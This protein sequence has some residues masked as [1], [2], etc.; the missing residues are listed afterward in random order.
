[1]EQAKLHSAQLINIE[2]FI[3]YFFLNTRKEINNGNYAKEKSKRGS[4]TTKLS[5]L[6]LF[7]VSFKYETISGHDVAGDFQQSG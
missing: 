2:V 6:S 3:Y 5:A 7:P 4:H 1:M